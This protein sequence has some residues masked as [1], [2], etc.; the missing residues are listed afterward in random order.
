MAGHAQSAALWSGESSG[1]TSRVTSKGVSVR[2]AVL[3]ATGVLIVTGALLSPASAHA[4]RES[5]AEELFRQGQRLMH[6]QE[7]DSACLKFE[8]SQRLDPATGTL[9]NLAVCHQKQ[10]RTATAWAEFRQAAELARRDHRPDRVEFA[11]QRAAELEAR[12]V[13]L[14][15]VLPPEV[16]ALDVTVALN[17]RLLGPGAYDVAFPVDPGEYLVTVTCPRHETW[18]KL[19][20]VDGTSPVVELVVPPPAP[21][22]QVPTRAQVTPSQQTGTED[23]K[24]PAEP[25]TLQPRSP[26]DAP[27]WT[28][29]GLAGAGILGVGLGSAFGIVAM[30]QSGACDGHDCQTPEDVRTFESAQDYAT[31]STVSFALG[32]AALAVAA[33]IWFLVPERKAARTMPPMD[34]ARAAIRWGRSGGALVEGSF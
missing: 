22:T 34:E 4:Q 32:G 21:R 9:L 28:S 7:V 16:T 33:A 8:E 25:W 2:C 1:R 11:E 26:L 23:G 27:R 14:K 10:G 20:V 5:L 3:I 18:E 29:V 19:V 30:V 24:S 6:A 12:L 31:A 17:A 15:L 13:R